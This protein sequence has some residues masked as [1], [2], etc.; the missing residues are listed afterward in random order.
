MTA[1]MWIRLFQ[2]QQRH[3]FHSWEQSERWQKQSLLVS[4]RIRSTSPWQRDR[5]SSLTRVLSHF[6]CLSIDRFPKISSLDESE[7]YKSSAVLKGMV[8]CNIKASAH[9][10]SL[11]YY[12][13]NEGFRKLLC[14]MN[15]VQVHSTQKQVVS[16]IVIFRWQYYTWRRRLVIERDASMLRTD[17]N[18]G[19]E[20][21]WKT[22]R[23]PS[24]CLNACYSRDN[25]ENFR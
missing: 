19:S 9:L 7:L 12:D 20:T 18:R 8:C 14:C 5:A 2:A 21:G 10:E 22:F 25:A 15:W 3:F 17:R 24:G 6:H 23:Q 13:V 1:W 4:S 11:A 16:R